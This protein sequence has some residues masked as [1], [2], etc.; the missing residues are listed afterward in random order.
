MRALGLDVAVPGSGPQQSHILT[1]GKLNAGG[2]GFS[3]DPLV[4]P[5]SEFLTANG[6]MH[7]LR[8]GQMRFGL[9]AYNDRA[10][11]VRALDV[12]REGIAAAKTRIA[13]AAP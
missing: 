7:T 4:Q 12:A 1:V 13:T 5:L 3:T 11:I 6:V 8:R 10:D 2:H 9:H